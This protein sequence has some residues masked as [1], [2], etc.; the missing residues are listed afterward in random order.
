LLVFLLLRGR[1][2]W[3]GLLALLNWWLI[4]LLCVLLLFFLNWGRW[5]RIF[6]LLKLLVIVLVGLQLQATGKCR[7]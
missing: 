1:R 5:R 4:F 7:F 2:R 3:W 6:S